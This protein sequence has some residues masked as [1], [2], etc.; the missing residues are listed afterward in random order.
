MS[1][2]NTDLSVVANTY[3]SNGEELADI[4]IRNLSN[5]ASGSTFTITP[6]NDPENV[7]YKGIAHA[8]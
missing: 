1:L 3:Y 7:L 8:F 2:G 4:Q 6:S 5:I